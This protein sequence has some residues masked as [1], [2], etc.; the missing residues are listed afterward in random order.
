M[1]HTGHGLTCVRVR[2]HTHTPSPSR[3]SGVDSLTHPPW[4]SP[5]RKCCSPH[6]KQT[7]VTASF[8]SP[9]TG[10]ALSAS[11]LCLW[12]MG[13]AP[14]LGVPIAALFTHQRVSSGTSPDLYP[15]RAHSVGEEAAQGGRALLRAHVAAPR[16]PEPGAAALDVMKEQGP[17]KCQ[18]PSKSLSRQRAGQ[19]AGPSPRF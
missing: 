19:R 16:D 5:N 17:C 6:S 9:P 14:Q 12:P 4:P 18:W 13:Q 3:P 11:F 1:D 2:A 15:Y 10:P 8:L 7:W